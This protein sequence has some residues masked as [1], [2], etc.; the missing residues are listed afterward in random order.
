M[1]TTKERPQA[2]YGATCGNKKNKNNNQ[3]QLS[4]PAY[5]C[6]VGLSGHIATVDLP[7]EVEASDAELYPLFQEGGFHE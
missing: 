2:V 3:D 6:Q 7:A 1:T 4:N 5:P